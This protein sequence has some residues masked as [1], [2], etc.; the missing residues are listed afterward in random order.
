MYELLAI[1][2]VASIVVGEYSATTYSGAHTDKNICSNPF[3][4]CN[5]GTTGFCEAHWDHNCCFAT[6]NLPYSMNCNEPSTCYYVCCNRPDTPC[7]NLLC[8]QSPEKCVNNICEVPTPKPTDPPP[9]AQPTPSPTKN[10]TKNKT[11]SHISIPV[12]I[13]ITVVVIILIGGSAYLIRREWRKRQRQRRPILLPGT[14]NNYLSTDISQ[15]GTKSTE[16]GNK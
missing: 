8:C 12:A 16:A 2:N 3:Y 10:K 7:G 5:S 9:T 6:S 15:A 4:S 1:I 14:V 13:I 11:K